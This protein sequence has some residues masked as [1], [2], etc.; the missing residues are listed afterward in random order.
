MASP[1]HPPDALRQIPRLGLMAGEGRFPILVAQ[2]ATQNAIPVTAFAIEGVTPPEL[3]GFVEQM[4]WL[5]LGQFSRFIDQL[6]ADDIRHVVMAG[7]VAH[8][9]LWRYR[10]FDVRS[11]RVLKN[12]VNRKA[13][14]LL[15]AVVE[16]LAR[17]NVTVIDSSLLLTECLPKKGLLTP[18]RPLTEREEKDIEFGLPLARQIAGLDIG[19]TIVVK[20]LAVV[21]VESLEG[22]DETIRRAGRIADGDIVVIKVSKPQQDRRFDLPV[23]GPETI[24]SIREAGGG[25]LAVMAGEALFFDQTEAIA[26]AHESNIAIVAV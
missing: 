24:R 21:A 9:N 22:T 19:Q 16:E 10:G 2:A 11:L 13:D 14:T 1:L 26:L 6:H 12:M 15:G 5:K 18:Q 17:E 23:V 20:D 8:N 25:A 4:H 3:A 7:R